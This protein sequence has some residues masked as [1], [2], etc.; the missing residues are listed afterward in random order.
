M[1]APEASARDL[2]KAAP[3]RSGQLLKFYLQCRGFETL[4]L[5]PGDMGL[6][7]CLLFLLFFGPRHGDFG[8]QGRQ[9]RLKGPLLIQQHRQMATLP[10]FGRFD[11]TEHPVKPLFFIQQILK[12]AIGRRQI[13]LC[14]IEL[15]LAK[16]DEGFIIHDSDLFFKA[17]NREK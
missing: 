13:A 8:I 7:E 10:R 4:G 9:G 5:L 17:P 11:L 14:P 6:F 15:L 16:F 2:I 1:I 3:L 12:F